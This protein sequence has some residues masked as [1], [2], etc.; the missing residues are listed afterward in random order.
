MAH[1]QTLTDR[2]TDEPSDRC[3]VKC[4]APERLL[5]DGGHVSDKDVGA[6]AEPEQ[7]RRRA[8]LRREIFLTDD[9]IVLFGDP[10]LWM[11]QM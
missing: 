10:F 7:A 2:Q 11:T 8:L 5:R 4:A 6:Q 3:I 1:K 9:T